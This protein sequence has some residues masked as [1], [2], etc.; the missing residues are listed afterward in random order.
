MNEPQTVFCEECKRDVV[1]VTV[2]ARK[3]VCRWVPSYAREADDEFETVL[4]GDIYKQCPQC[5]EVFHVSY[6]D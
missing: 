6:F 3:S 4:A 1:P 2:D 5:G